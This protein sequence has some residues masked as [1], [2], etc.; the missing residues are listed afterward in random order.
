MR[1]GFQPRVINI[2]PRSTLARSL[3]CMKMLAFGSEACD[4]LEGRCLGSSISLR[5]TAEC[6][7]S[8]RSVSLFHLS[9]GCIRGVG[10][11]CV[12]WGWCFVCCLFCLDCFLHGSCLGPIG[13]LFLQTFGCMWKNSATATCSPMEAFSTELLIQKPS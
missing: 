9:P 7:G 11:V 2:L 3:Y 10:S 4:D 12:G 1:L 6:R 13:L 8:G 5:S